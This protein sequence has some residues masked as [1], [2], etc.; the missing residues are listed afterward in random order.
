MQARNS[1]FDLA[2]DGLRDISPFTK[3]GGRGGHGIRRAAQVTKDNAPRG[4]NGENGATFWPSSKRASRA[5]KTSSPLATHT[6]AGIPGDSANGRQRRHH[7]PG[8]RRIPGQAHRSH[9]NLPVQQE[10]P[11]VEAAVPIHDRGAERA[12]PRPPSP[13]SIPWGSGSRP[14]Q[15]VSQHGPIPCRPLPWGNKEPCDDVVHAR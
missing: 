5:W 3:N 14:F 7:S 12:T 2:T 11:A 4:R 8:P 1:L 15:G 13:R 9:T 10:C 6:D